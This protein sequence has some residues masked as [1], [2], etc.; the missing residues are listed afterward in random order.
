MHESREQENRENGH[1]PRQRAEFMRGVGDPVKTDQ[2]QSEL[3]DPGS[4]E[5]FFERAFFVDQPQ[6][7]RN[8]TKQQSPWGKRDVSGADENSRQ[9]GKSFLLD[10]LKAFLHHD[11]V[12]LTSLRGDFYGKTD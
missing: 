9:K 1:G 2:G 3:R 5:G 6:P 8:I 12:L 11:I 4:P 10:P 7:E